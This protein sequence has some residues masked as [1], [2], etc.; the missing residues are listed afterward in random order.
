MAI[1]RSINKEVDYT[2]ISKEQR[3]CIPIDKNNLPDYEKL[4][5]NISLVYAN[6]SMMYSD[7]TMQIATE[8]MLVRIKDSYDVKKIL[9][10]LNIVYERIRL[11]GHNVNSYLI[12]LKN[13]ESY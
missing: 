9:D 5:N 11:I 10:K 1:A 6:Q 3:I 7:G 2:E 12:V 4:K 8:E 13:G